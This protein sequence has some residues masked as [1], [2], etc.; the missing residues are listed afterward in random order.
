[1]VSD[2]RSELE[3]QLGTLRGQLADI[4]HHWRGQGSTAFQGVMTR[5]DEN[6]RRIT[7]ALNDF[8]ANL[9]SSEQTYN[10]SDEQQSSSFTNLSGRMG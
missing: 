5:W 6:T 2:A 1:M 3:A 8:E 9:R 7:G 4:G 10:A